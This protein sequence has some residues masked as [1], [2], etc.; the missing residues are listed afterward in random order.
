MAARGYTLAKYLKDSGIGSGSVPVQGMIGE[1]MDLREHAASLRQRAEAKPPLDL[2]FIQP[3]VIV[4]LKE[5]RYVEPKVGD[6]TPTGF[7]I[8]KG[9]L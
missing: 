4:Q 9:E 5:P 1:I 3:D 2:D 8:V 7:D 6:K